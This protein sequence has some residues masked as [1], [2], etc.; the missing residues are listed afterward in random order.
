MKANTSA[1]P[2]SWLARDA[3][4]SSGDRADGERWRG[5]PGAS[6]GDSDE[7][8]NRVAAANDQPTPT[9]GKPRLQ[10]LETFDDEPQLGMPHATVFHCGVQD[11]DEGEWSVRLQRSH[12]RVR[13]VEPKIAA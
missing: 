13:V 3:A 12:N 1:V 10:I 7:L 9:L 8:L 2:T 11:V 4:S 5:Q 6:G